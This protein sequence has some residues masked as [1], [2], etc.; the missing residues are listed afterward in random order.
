M[1]LGE[2]RERRCVHIGRSS[3]CRRP[4]SLA[5]SALFLSRSQPTWLRRDNAPS[6]R[7]QDHGAQAAASSQHADQRPS[8]RR[9]APWRRPGHPPGRTVFRRLWP[10]QQ[11][12]AGAADDLQA[13]R[14]NA[15]VAGVSSASSPSMPAGRCRNGDPVGRARTGRPGPAGSSHGAAWRASANALSG[16]RLPRASLPKCVIRYLSRLIATSGSRPRCR[17]RAPERPTPGQLL[18]Y[19]TCRCAWGTSHRMNS[20]NFVES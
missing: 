18:R 12:P 4:A 7:D 14:V 6:G 16:P 13:C 19:I 9:T 3:A 10:P 17:Q 1:T 5:P 20:I 8:A 2:P 11:R 15:C